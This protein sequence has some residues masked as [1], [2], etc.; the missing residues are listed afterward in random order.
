MSAFLLGAALF[1]VVLALG[2]AFLFTQLLARDRGGP[3]PPD[4]EDVFS[5]ARYKAMER[6]LEDTDYEYVGTGGNRNKRIEH[7]LRSKRI[8][9]FH[10]YV[11]CLA[12]DFTRICKAIRKLMVDSDV[13]R[14]DL[15]GLLMKQNFV[16]TLAILHIEFNLI[17]YRFGIGNPDGKALV[18]SLDTMYG[19]LRTLALIVEPV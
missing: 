2:F 5:P 11:N 1:L 14:P 4:W 13:D 12:Q 16:F 10:D 8:Q 19:Q 7:Q 15:A 9:I 17:L 6:L 18:Q 3:L